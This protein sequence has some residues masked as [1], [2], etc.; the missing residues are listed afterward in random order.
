MNKTAL[1]YGIYVLAALTVIV[2]AMRI[3]P[4]QPCGCSGGIPLP[5]SIIYVV[6]ENENFEEDPNINCEARGVASCHYVI[7]FELLVGIVILMVMMIGQQDPPKP[8]VGAS[9]IKD[10]RK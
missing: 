2:M 6:W 8:Y 5:Q 1:T 10:S 9:L 4:P 3:H 7:P